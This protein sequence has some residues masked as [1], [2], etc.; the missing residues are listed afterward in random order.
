MQVV[1]LVRVVEHANPGT[2][3]AGSQKTGYKC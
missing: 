2:Y 1:A 3:R